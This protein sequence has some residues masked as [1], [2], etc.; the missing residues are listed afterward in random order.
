MKS[1][2]DHQVPV[3]VGETH[4]F[5]LLVLEGVQLEHLLY[6]DHVSSNLP[7]LQETS[8]SRTHVTRSPPSPPSVTK[9]RESVL[10]LVRFVCPKNL[11][12][13]RTTFHHQIYSTGVGSE[14]STSHT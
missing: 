8:V 13:T 1:H 3:T 7:K 4:P 6:T 12:R 2:V 5:I 9:S 10:P 11:F 14:S